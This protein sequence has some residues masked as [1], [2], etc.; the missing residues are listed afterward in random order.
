MVSQV[1]FLICSPFGLQNDTLVVSEAIF[2]KVGNNEAMILTW[3]IHDPFEHVSI[4]LSLARDRG[5]SWDGI[6]EFDRR[7]SLLPESS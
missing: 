3:A 2:G 4:G 7:L 5:Y 6:L 1:P